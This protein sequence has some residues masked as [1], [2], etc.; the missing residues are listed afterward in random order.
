[1]SVPNY[2]NAPLTA[3]LALVLTATATVGAS[4]Q[5]VL[6]REGLTVEVL[7]LHRWTLEMLQDSLARHGDSLHTHACAATLRY[8]LG[9]PEAAATR[10]LTSPDSI[11]IIVSVVEPHDSARVRHRHLPFDTAVRPAWAPLATI[12]RSRPAAF[13]LALSAYDPDGPA[14]MVPWL[15]ENLGADTMHVR[16]VW[17]FLAERR[18][19]ASFEDAVRTV[20]ADPGI[21]NRMIAAATLANFADRDQSWWVLAEALRERDGGVKAIASTVLLNRARAHPR[22]VD[23][24]PAVPTIHALLRGTALFELPSTMQWLP[25][26]SDGPRWSAEFL[27]HGGEMV[28]TYLGSRHRPLRDGARRLLVHLRGEDLG[29]LREP[30]EDWIAKGARPPCPG[31]C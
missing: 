26:M 18:D 22:P 25:L 4:A 16:R 11:V 5:S 17:D 21:Y 27:A 12:I 6:Q 24:G 29:P 23:W 7:G 30:W 1:M 8:K 28:L 2:W 14:V 3:A 19:A 13:Q 9:F 15:V 10:D 31:R 20:L